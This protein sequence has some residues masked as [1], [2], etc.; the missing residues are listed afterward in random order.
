MSKDKEELQINDNSKIEDI[1][2]FKTKLVHFLKSIIPTTI[3][4][5]LSF[6][7]IFLLHYFGAYNSLELKLK[8]K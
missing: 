4:G 2:G 6:V 7:I 5:L 8:R 3:I 1:F